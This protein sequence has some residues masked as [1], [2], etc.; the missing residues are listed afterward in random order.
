MST[1]VEKNGYSYKI[2]HSDIDLK[3]RKQVEG[4]ITRICAE[5]ISIHQLK[6]VDHRKFLFISH[7]SEVRAFLKL[8]D[9][10]RDNRN[11]GIFKKFDP[12]TVYRR[13][14][15]LNQTTKI[16]N[17]LWRQKLGLKTENSKLYE[18][19]INELDPYPPLIRFQLKD[20]KTLNFFAL[21]DYKS[22]VIPGKKIPI[23]R[24][25]KK[26]A[27]FKWTYNV[28][29][30]NARKIKRRVKA[31]K[32]ILEKKYLPKIKSELRKIGIMDVTQLSIQ[33]S[34][35]LAGLIMMNHSKYSH[36]GWLPIIEMLKNG[37]CNNTCA[38]YTYKL[39]FIFEALKLMQKKNRSRLLNTY[40]INA[41]GF[42]HIWNVFVTITSKS[43]Y[44]VT[45]IDV[46]GADHGNWTDRSYTWSRLVR[47]LNFTRSGRHFY[48][49]LRRLRSSGL[50]PMEEEL[51]VL[52]KIIFQG[53]FSIKIV[54][55]I[56]E[57]LIEK[58]SLQKTEQKLVE[59][60]I[61]RFNVREI[62]K[63]SF[64]NLL[65]FLAN[66]SKIQGALKGNN[67]KRKIARLLKLAE[68]SLYKHY[69][70][71]GKDIYAQIDLLE[72]T[73]RNCDLS[74]AKKEAVT[75]LETERTKQFLKLYLAFKDSPQSRKRVFDILRNVPMNKRTVE[76]YAIVI[77][78]LSLPII[79]YTEPKSRRQ[80][81]QLIDYL[82]S[83]L[84]IRFSKN[85][86]AISL[87]L[88]ESNPNISDGFLYITINPYKRGAIKRTKILLRKA[89]S[90]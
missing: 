58:K 60:I 16:W 53:Y 30:L 45:I 61:N 25:W 64:D 73:F 40:C 29:H 34:I 21:K 6:Y 7:D 31:V 48:H 42:N 52:S 67:I 71:K 22:K 4:Q 37:G 51:K 77:S 65:P 62:N 1:K 86:Q 39:Y 75:A 35:V 76:Y 50:I 66:L 81:H 88:E 14:H 68:R 72:I 49:I 57:I 70:K 83:L 10:Y 17:V 24:R 36:R 54:T 19:L 18:L 84:N 32:E 3:G 15:K 56:L 59:K 13:L 55:R 26:D 78:A 85:M 87:F 82:K 11:V 20:N 5:N 28:N 44:Q 33:Q 9:F 89:F 79:I 90:Y 47:R 69:T 27:L 23:R 41:Q 38:G 46:T 2:D 80:L 8:W 12:L 43:E 74:E 63:T